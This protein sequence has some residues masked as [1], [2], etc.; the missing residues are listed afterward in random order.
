MRDHCARSDHAEWH[1]EKKRDLL[2]YILEA[3][4]G[5]MPKLLPLKYERMAVSPFGLYRGSVWLMARDLGR[6]RSSG[7]EAQICGDAHIRNLGCFAAP[8]G[9]LLFD[10]N[11]FD[12]TT[13]APF[14]W[15]LKR[16]ATSLV[17]AGREA[18]LDDEK[19]GSAVT[20]MAGSYRTRMHEMSE[21]NFLELARYKGRHVPS[22][23]VHDMLRKAERA[24]PQHSLASLTVSTPRKQP[25]FKR[26][27]PVLTP[28]SGR[29][30]GMLGTALRE[31][32]GTLG[33]P[34]QVLLDRYTP[35]DYAFKVVGT[36]SV[37][38]RDYVVLMLGHA[39]Q[40]RT[41]RY[42]LFLQ[43]KQ[44][45]PSA[46]SVLKRGAHSAWHH[47]GH[48]VVE[49]TRLMQAATDPLL[50]WTSM[51]SRNYLVRQLNDHKASL[52]PTDLAIPDALADYARV[53]GAVLARAH[54]RTA[55][56]A[57][58]DGYCG[59]SGDKAGKDDKFDRAIA[60]FAFRYAEQVAADYAQFRK[61]LRTHR[62]RNS[63][64]RVGV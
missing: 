10:L 4:A 49:G 37:G 52:E 13:R 63:G 59:T 28:V 7:I 46:Y 57:V 40:A 18:Q 51:E 14:E 32:R 29:T 62:I 27:P 31:Y 61:L 30:R 44:A 19:I 3:Q 23:A 2:P 6:V 8:D 41:S 26:Q 38:L 9:S 17:L 36:G 11:D 42:P 16:L 47:D 56:P 24:T 33:A 55:D 22:Q 34:Q 64:K 12:E 35:V 15:D 48:R 58:L 21:L 1:V 5:R 39:S 53:C 50:G 25:H 60:K 45:V 54:S 20:A 43:I